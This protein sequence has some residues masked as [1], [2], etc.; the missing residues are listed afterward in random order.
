MF[1]L[2]RRYRLKALNVFRVFCQAALSVSYRLR[3]M[4]SRSMMDKVADTT[5][6]H[7]LMAH[8]TVFGVWCVSG[9]YVQKTQRCH[10]LSI[11]SD[12]WVIGARNIHQ[13]P[14]QSIT[15]KH[16]RRQE[17]TTTSYLITALTTFNR[18]ERFQF[19]WLVGIECTPSP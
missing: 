3:S 6:H 12:V 13:L 17:H 7:W 15:S 19:N 2:E 4:P 16:H 18:C 10:A 8:G 1:I 9:L 11:S 14:S 5:R